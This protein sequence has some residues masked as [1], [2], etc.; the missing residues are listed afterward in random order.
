MLGPG[1]KFTPSQKKKII[2]SNMERNGGSIKSDL[3]G[4]TLVPATKCQKG[5]TPNP[6]EVQIN[7]IFPRSRGGSNSYSNAQVLSRLENI[8]KSDK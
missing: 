6:L 2:D 3:S 7:H 1:K 4:E 5:V 8:L